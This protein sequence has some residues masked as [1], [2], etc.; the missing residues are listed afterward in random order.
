MQT[1]HACVYAKELDGGARMHDRLRA[2]RVKH[3]VAVE[4]VPF[5]YLGLLLLTLVRVHQQAALLLVEV[6]TRRPIIMRWPGT[7]GVASLPANRVNHSALTTGSVAHA[8]MRDEFEH[9]RRFST[10]FSMDCPCGNP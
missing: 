7:Y 8:M 6:L 2:V 9:L 10:P 4:K 5:A 3:R 1:V